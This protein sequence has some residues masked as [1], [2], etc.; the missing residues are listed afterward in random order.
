VSSLSDKTFNEFIASP[1]V[2]INITHGVLASCR[3][4][5]SEVQN[6][7]LKNRENK[8]QAAAKATG[9]SVRGNSSSNNGLPKK[10]L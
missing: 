7:L 2:I 10:P 8:N 4:E 5:Q 6:E 9:E 3:A 1:P